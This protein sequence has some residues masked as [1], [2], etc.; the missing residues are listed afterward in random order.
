MV[1]RSIWARVLGV[2]VM[3]LGFG[4]CVHS[5]GDLCYIRPGANRQEVINA[6]GPPASAAASKNTELFRYELLTAQSNNNSSGNAVAQVESYF[7]RIIDGSVESYGKWSDLPASE[8][9]VD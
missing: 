7:V 4:G 3:L 5:A 8:K 1:M 2:C 6:L 9:K